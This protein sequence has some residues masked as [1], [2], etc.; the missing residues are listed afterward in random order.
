MMLIT[1]VISITI[2]CLWIAIGF[3]TVYN[4]NCLFK[5]GPEKE[6]RNDTESN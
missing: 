3:W 6:K 4:I 5:L 2:A 1:A